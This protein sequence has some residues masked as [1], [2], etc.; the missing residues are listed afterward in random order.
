MSKFKIGDIARLKYI[1]GG[2]SSYWRPGAVVTVI[3][4]H[5]GDTKPGS[6]P[7]D[8]LVKMEDG[9]IGFPIEDQ[10]E[11]IVKNDRKVR[12][13]EMERKFGWNPTKELETC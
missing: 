6:A 9:T 2:A 8:Y 1:R 11:P 10:L 3:D 5:L 12:W 13:E 4:I 7:Y